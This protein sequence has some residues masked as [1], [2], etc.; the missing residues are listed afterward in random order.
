[1]SAEQAATLCIRLYRRL[2]GAFPDEFHRACG[3]EM[4]RTTEDLIWDTGWL[5]QGMSPRAGVEEMDS[6]AQG[7]EGN[8]CLSIG[9]DPRCT[10]ACER[11]ACGAGQVCTT[12]WLNL[13]IPDDPGCVPFC[14]T[15][16]DCGLGT[17]CDTRFGNCGAGAAPD[18]FLEYGEP[19][20]TNPNPAAEGTVYS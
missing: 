20:Q 18:D 5:G 11:G 16:A 9:S 19:C 10:R 4:V 7:G 1:M 15:D 2:A 6:E 14:H 17:R 12:L 13:P 8:T 3:R